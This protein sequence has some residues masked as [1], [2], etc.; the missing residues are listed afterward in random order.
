MTTASSKQ[1]KT[2][3]P[4]GY[5]KTG[6]RKKGSL[7]KRTLEAAAKLDEMGCDPLEM[8]AMIAMGE[9]LQTDH[10][11]LPRIIRY[12]DRL[13][14][15]HKNKTVKQRHIDL[16]ESNIR[17]ALTDTYVPLELRSK[18]VVDL[19]QYLYPKRAAIKHTGAMITY[20]NTDAVPDDVLM[21]IIT[22]EVSEES[23]LKLLE[24][25]NKE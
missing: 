24:G 8:S 4:R 3:K 1:G 6:G 12:I 5:P 7:G 17:K 14:E 25:D 19:M 22:G 2:T 18:H 21:G 9:H 15:A 16:I 13:R 20:N 11:M 23:L 10:P